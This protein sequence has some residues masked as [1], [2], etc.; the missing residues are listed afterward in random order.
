VN[1]LDLPGSPTAA[2]ISSE[3]AFVPVVED[4]ASS[5][6][7]IV[8]VKISPPESASLVNSISLPGYPH[9]IT[10][11]GAYAYATAGSSIQV[12]DIKTP[13]SPSILTSY[14]LPGFA[15]AIAVSSGLA[16]VGSNGLRI[17]RLW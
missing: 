11:S 1:T 6:Y 8:V 13:D 17:I 14:A 4:W 16:Y 5:K 9:E 10:I 3:F 15:R 2:A 12:I 7:S